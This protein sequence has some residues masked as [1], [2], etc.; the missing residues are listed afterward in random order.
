MEPNCCIFLKNHHHSWYGSIN[1]IVN[2]L[3]TTNTDINLLLKKTL[4]KFKNNVKIFL[5]H[6]LSQN[7][8]SKL[9]NS[10]TVN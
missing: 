8:K 7:G 4:G 6:F 3:K 10:L 9:I 2:I 5:N 1:I